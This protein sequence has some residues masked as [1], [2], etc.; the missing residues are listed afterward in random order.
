[1]IEL[2]VLNRNLERIDIID[3]Y[4]SL[5][6]ANRYDDIGDCELY[7]EANEK[8]FELLKPGNYLIRDDD[9]MVC[10]IKNI[11]LD[12][13]SETGNHLIVTGYDVKD[14]LN[15]RIIWRLINS[16]G[17]AEEYIRKIIYENLINPKYPERQIKDST[18]RAN[19]FL[20]PLVGFEE[21]II[22]QS[23]YK[24][25]QEKVQ[26]IC[27]KYNWGYK[28][29][30]NEKE[31]NFYFILY[32]GTDRSEFVVFSQDFENIISTNY[33]EN[34]SNLANVA[35]VGGEG[36]GSQRLKNI[37]GKADGLD[38]YELFVDAKDISKTITWSDL[39]ELY[40]TIEQ[41]GY[42]YIEDTVYKVEKID[43]LIVDA[44]QLN[45]LKEKYPD[46]K[47]IT[48]NKI[49]YYQIENVEIAELPTS[50]PEDG[51]DIILKDLLYS[52]FLLNRGYEKLAE[53]GATKSFGGTIEPNTT[54]EYKKDYFLGDIVNVTNEYG[55]T[56]DARIV[57]VIEVCDENGYSVEPTFKY[58]E[59]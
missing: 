2:Y 35:L 37:S 23:S 24:N 30:I 31:K 13:N 12:T 44:N 43:I 20:G 27:K 29:I 17:K 49:Q 57:E 50:S 55:L 41:G 18:G 1:M 14:I 53:Y 34:N 40:P 51:T 47:I 38:R 22:E 45:E 10:R 36:E 59:E 9:D 16:E 48:E 26:E 19:F 54:F 52:A 28:I 11:E 33:I 15:Q 21:N 56:V 8:Y 6:W 39:I 32:K 42:G 25:V 3:S 5:I 4:T 7:V 58:M 46:G